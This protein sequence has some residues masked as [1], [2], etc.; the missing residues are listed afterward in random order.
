VK[1]ANKL[2]WRTAFERIR[3]APQPEFRER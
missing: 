2:S 3:S 1:S